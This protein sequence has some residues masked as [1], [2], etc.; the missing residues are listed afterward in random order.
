MKSFSSALALALLLGMGCT[1]ED[2]CWY[3]DADVDTDMVASDTDK[4]AGGK[5]DAGS[6]DGTDQI[7]GG[8]IELVDNLGV[9]TVTGT[10]CTSTFDLDVTDLDL[11]GC[12]DCTEARTLVAQPSDDDACAASDFVVGASFNIGHVPP[13]TLMIDKS[14][15]SV[16][17]TSSISGDTWSF[18]FGGK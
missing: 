2:D 4:G 7:H 15:W 11:E 10:D 1:P 17:G 18:T 12:P 3:C 13:G 16:G 14:G 8:T 9:Y 5:V 6:K